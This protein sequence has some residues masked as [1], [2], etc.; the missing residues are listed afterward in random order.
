MA[1]RILLYL[2][3]VATWCV[4]AS[5]PVAVHAQATDGNIVGAVYD[6]TGAALPKVEIELLNAATGIRATTNT[7]A[8]GSYRFGNVLIGE[9]RIKATAP[10]F[11]PVSVKGVMVALNRTTTANFTM[12][13]GSVSSSIEVT[14]AAALIDASSAQITSTYESR[15]ATELP[16]SS[17]PAGGIL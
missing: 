5:L 12:T 15:L 8:Q 1:P 16:N 17:N 7:D 13:L 14:A 4:L 11:A 9:Y 3:L 10:G 2:P 6:P